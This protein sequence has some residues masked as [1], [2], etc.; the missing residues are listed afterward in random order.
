MKRI[1]GRLE[2]PSDR[3]LK[4]CEGTGLTLLDR[5]GNSLGETARVDWRPRTAGLL[6]ERIDR[7][8]TTVSGIVKGGGLR[9]QCFLKSLYNPFLCHFY[10]THLLL[11]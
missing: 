1:R 5:V 8:F 10:Y 6:V 9:E 4:G 7:L 3:V 2:V 11:Y